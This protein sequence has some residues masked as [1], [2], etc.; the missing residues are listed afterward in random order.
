MNQKIL[1]TKVWLV[2]RQPPQPSLGDRETKPENKLQTKK[3]AFVMQTTRGK[4]DHQDLVS[5]TSTEP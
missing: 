4:N 3:H 1:M 2:V 5:K